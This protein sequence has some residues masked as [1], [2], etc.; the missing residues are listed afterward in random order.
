MQDACGG[1]KLTGLC[2]CTGPHVLLAAKVPQT[3]PRSRQR[4]QRCGQHNPS[5]TGRA[6]HAAVRGLGWVIA[7]GLRAESSR[8][9]KT[10]KH[11]DCACSVRPSRTLDQVCDV[12]IRIIKRKDRLAERRVEAPRP[13]NDPIIPTSRPSVLNDGLDRLVI[14]LALKAAREDHD[15][16]LKLQEE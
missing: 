5:L 8:P 3:A 7:G 10:D 13:A 16:E 9:G 2:P 14:S 15:K 11:A 6:D 12:S 1:G 4:P